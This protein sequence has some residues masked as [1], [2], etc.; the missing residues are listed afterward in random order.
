LPLFKGIRRFSW[1]ILLKSLPLLGQY[2]VIN[3]FCLVRRPLPVDWFCLRKW[4]SLIN[5]FTNMEWF[6]SFQLVTYRLVN[7]YMP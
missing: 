7:K 1:F 3:W 5:E 2:F 6:L 4:F